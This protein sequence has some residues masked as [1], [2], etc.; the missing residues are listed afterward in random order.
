MCVSLRASPNYW[1][2]CGI[3]TL[4]LYFGD[5]SIVKE[6]LLSQFL[7]Q[8]ESRNIKARTQWDQINY[9]V[10]FY[11]LSNCVL[12]IYSSWYKYRVKLQIEKIIWNEN[13]DK[14]HP[15]VPGRKPFEEASCWDAASQ[16]SILLGKI[17]QT[18]GGIMMGVIFSLFFIFF[19]FNKSY[20]L[21]LSFANYIFLLNFHLMKLTNRYI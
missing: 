12:L 14:I 3:V 15:I 17:S 20:E 18:P 6:F 4:C 16:S 1:F 11:F 8:C 10:I 13:S 2:H 21:Q 7:G 9:E 5:L 19:L